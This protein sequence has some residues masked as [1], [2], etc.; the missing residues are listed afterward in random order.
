MTKKILSSNL[1]KKTG[2]IFHIL[3]I[4]HL[5]HIDSDLANKIQNI[6]SIYQMKTVIFITRKKTC[7]QIELKYQ[8]VFISFF[9]EVEVMCG[10]I[11]EQNR[12]MRMGITLYKCVHTCLWDIHYLPLPAFLKRRLCMLSA[13]HWAIKQ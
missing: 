8:S 2:P 4:W 10:F 7:M 1:I 3:L 11:W 13:L 5:I 6:L 12:C 9:I